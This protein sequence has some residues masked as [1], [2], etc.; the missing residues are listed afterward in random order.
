MV[1]PI[2]CVIEHGS[3]L[4][5]RVEYTGESGLLVP[6]VTGHAVIVL[7]NQP[8]AECV[9]GAR[10]VYSGRVLHGDLPAIQV[11]NVT[12]DAGNILHRELLPGR[13]PGVGDPGCIDVPY[14][15]I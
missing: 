7:Q 2:Q 1:F 15:S 10:Q 11:V 13:I 8:V 12:G 9:Q 4:V 3:L 14:V 6:G 5:T